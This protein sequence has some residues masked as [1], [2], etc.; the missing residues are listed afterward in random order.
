[1]RNNLVNNG[2]IYLRKIESNDLSG[3]VM[4]W[5]ERDD[6]MKFYTNSKNVIT[7][8]GLLSFIKKNEVDKTSYTYG[9]FD[10][11]T[12][13][14]IG[15]IKIGPINLHHKISDLVVLL[16]NDKYRGKGIATMAIGLGQDLAFNS[17]D[18]RKL[19]GGMYE[20]NIPSI[21]AYLRA[22]WIVEGRLSD[23]YLVNDKSED[24]LLV[25]NFNH[26]YF[27]IDQIEKIKEREKLYYEK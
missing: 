12:D 16:G 3:P 24:R 17:L 2:V 22:G 26:K 14:I 4:S 9:F 20:S 1:M 5:F 18:I 27:S 8:E 25:A 19:F 11:E 7:K 15:T 23:Q 10:C 6:L 13:E 21:K